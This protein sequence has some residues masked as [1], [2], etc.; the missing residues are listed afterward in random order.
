[1][2]VSAQEHCRKQLRD[3][4]KALDDAVRS[5]QPAKSGSLD[6]VCV[7]VDSCALVVDVS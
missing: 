3:P 7:S 6:R 4:V 2:L 5:G 1:M